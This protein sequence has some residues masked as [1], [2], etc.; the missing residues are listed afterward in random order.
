MGILVQKYG[1][2]SVGT[3]DRINSV[4]KR[5]KTSIE[6][7]H[8]VVIV[9]SAMAGVTNQLVSY[10]NSVHSYEGDR[11][12]DVI[13]SSGEQ[14]AAGLIAM[15]LKNLGLDAKSYMAWQLPIITDTNHGQAN[16][17][18]VYVDK[19]IADIDL[20]VIP[21]IC[22]FQG[23]S[24]LDEVTTIGRGGSD[25]TAVAVAA[26]L[27]ADV[28]EI[29]SDVDG[30]YTADP[31][32]ISSAKLIKS[33]N[34]NEMLEFSLNGAKVLQG[35]A[36]DY[37]MKHNVK[38]RAAS[39]FINSHGTLVSANKSMDRDIIGICSSSSLVNFN[40]SCSKIEKIVDTL[41]DNFI[42][43]IQQYMSD[44]ECV[45]TINH[46]DIRNACQV[47]EPLFGRKYRFVFQNSELCN[48]SLVGLGIGDN[49]DIENIVKVSLRGIKI[50]NIT[51]LRDSI[52]ITVRQADELAVLTTLHN[53]FV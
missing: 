12:Y 3:L 40:V 38:I 36:I 41:N 46:C 26:A 14:I 18:D 2:T 5:I 52:N 27:K 50:F 30:V 22:G 48:V 20:G 37:A 42:R 43:V 29:Y 35:K 31:N 44:G 13:I 19:I 32:K 16:I 49:R 24:R 4:A 28:C 17:L 7:G 33:I 1:G 6:Q 10:A 23:V 39:S 25:L 53:M 34:Y 9:V 51:C 21:I 8:Q 47:L 11:E 15:S 45:V